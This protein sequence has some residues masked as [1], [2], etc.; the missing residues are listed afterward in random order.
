[1]DSRRVS[2]RSS[3]GMVRFLFCL[4]SS[5]LLAAPALADQVVMKNGDQYRGKVICL[6]NDSLVFQS[7]NL[8]KLSLSK[9]QI[10]TITFGSVARAELRGVKSN[11]V[12]RQSQTTSQ[13]PRVAAGTPGSAEL[14]ADLSRL[15]AATNSMAYRDLLSQ[16]GPE[17][18][19]HFNEMV[20]GLMTGKLNVNDIR[21][22][23]KATANQVRAMRSEFGEE[24]GA[25]IDSYLAILDGFLK[26]SEPAN[27]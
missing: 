19:K 20:R 2:E 22:Q 8:G 13:A 7:E 24:G 12:S 4:F 14:A 10:D 17:A 18:T 16:A 15:Q 6:T 27:Q 26:E 1:M 11:T 9:P 21:K 3:Q 25:V 5:A 23:A